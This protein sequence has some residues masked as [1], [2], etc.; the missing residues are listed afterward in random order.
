[1]DYESAIKVADRTLVL[2]KRREADTGITFHKC[3]VLALLF[4][5]S[6]AQKDENRN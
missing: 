5:T 3:I 4:F 2:L 6:D 1:M